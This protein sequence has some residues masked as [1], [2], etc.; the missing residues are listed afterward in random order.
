MIP[1]TPQIRAYHR[2]FNVA[3]KKTLEVS[4]DDWYPDD[5]L[6]SKL[7]SLYKADT[8]GEIVTAIEKGGAKTQKDNMGIQTARIVKGVSNQCQTAALDTDATVN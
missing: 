7:A 4:A 3:D 8:V 2:C 6:L 1:T 5:E